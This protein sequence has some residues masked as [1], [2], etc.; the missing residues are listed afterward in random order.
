MIQS[1][2]TKKIYTIF[3]SF[4]EQRRICI[5]YIYFFLLSNMTNS[6]T[7]FLNDSESPFHS[8]EH[9]QDPIMIASRSEQLQ[10]T[11]W[12]YCSESTALASRQ[13]QRRLTNPQQPLNLVALGRTGDG[14][15]SLLNDLLGSNVFA[16]K[17][18]A[19][20]RKECT[21]LVSISV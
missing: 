4:K 10:K 16:Q 11:R 6:S 20:V 17:I 9:D 21:A 7:S 14:K 13:M 15:S 1:P 8:Y 18:S 3:V 5:A 2:Q 19:K 12:R